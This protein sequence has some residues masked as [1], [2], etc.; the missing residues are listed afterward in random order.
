[1]NDSWKFLIEFFNSDKSIVDVIN[2][3]LK[4]DKRVRN[5]NVDVFLSDIRSLLPNGNQESTY[6]DFLK[7]VTPKDFLGKIEKDEVLEI[8]ENRFLGIDMA[9][10]PYFALF[11]LDIYTEWFLYDKEYIEKW[12]DDNN[13]D[14]SKISDYFSNAEG[15]EAFLYPLMILLIVLRREYNDSLK[16]IYTKSKVEILK[17]IYIR[18]K[19]EILRETRRPFLS[20]IYSIYNQFDFANADIKEEIQKYATEDHVILPTFHPLIIKNIIGNS[21]RYSW[22]FKELNSQDVRKEQ[23]SD[24]E[25]EFDKK[26]DGVKRLLIDY[27]FPYTKIREND[28]FIIDDTKPSY[29]INKIYISLN[30][31]KEYE[32]ICFKYQIDWSNIPDESFDY[33]Q[34]LANKKEDDSRIWSLSNKLKDDGVFLLVK[35][36]EE[37]E[38]DEIIKREF[39]Y[40]RHDLGNMR[41]IC[42]MDFDIDYLNSDLDDA[43]LILD[44]LSS[45]D[46]GCTSDCLQ[47]IRRIIYRSKENAQKIE[48]SNSIIKSYINAAGNSEKIDRKVDIPLK[49]YLEDFQKY[50]SSKKLKVSIEVKDDTHIQ[51]CKWVL[52]LIILTVFENAERHGFCKKDDGNSEIRISVDET[53]SNYILKICNNGEPIM[54][55]LVDY[56]TRGIFRGATGHTGIGGFQIY[57]YAKMQGGDLKVVSCYHKSK[58][59]SPIAKWNTEIHLIIRK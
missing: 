45:N 13:F 50:F 32:N 33:I 26:E 57:R 55:E 56:I 6:L 7:V 9:I 34:I 58:V 22:L 46:N 18:R 53:E 17:D 29:L 10:G 5:T 20:V 36:K 21:D 31:S 35:T 25:D 48:F 42:T 52:T 54:I 30:K 11:A 40:F 16:D 41:N 15:E 14:M 43:K 2:K 8:T 27:L 24:T 38:I 4:S 28:Y 19:I 49:E 39:S 12:I 47:K 44:T 23:Y 3:A 1:M 37:Y 51:Y 59:Y